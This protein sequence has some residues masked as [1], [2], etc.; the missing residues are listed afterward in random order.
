VVGSVETVERGLRKFIEVTQPDEVIVT[1]LM[2][3]Q[4]E[5]LRSY[6]LVAQ[7]AEGMNAVDKAGVR[8]NEAARAV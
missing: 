8:R 3:G 6:Q 7:I 5:R 2:N 1:G 4:A